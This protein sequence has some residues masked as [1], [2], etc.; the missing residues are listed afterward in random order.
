LSKDDPEESKDLAAG[1]N[2]VVTA[3]PRAPY[4]IRWQLVGWWH[5][6]E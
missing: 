3:A 4:E 5:D 2:K 6:E 1:V